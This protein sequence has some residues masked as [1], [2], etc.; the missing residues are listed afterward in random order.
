MKI[1]VSRVKKW[2]L[3]LV[4]TVM[5]TAAL[6]VSAS[7]AEDMIATAKANKVTSGKLV[8]NSKGIRF[9]Y[10][11]GKYAKNTWLY[12][13]SKVYSFK[14]NGYANKGF[15]TYNG[16][17]YYADSKGRVY[18]K[19]WVTKS[20]K[21]YYLRATGE[22]AANVTLKLNGKIYKFDSKGLVVKDSGA[23]KAT[24][25]FVGDSRTVGM[26]SA[27]GGTANLYIGKV[28]MGYNWLSKTADAKIRSY[29][30]ENPKLKVIFAFGVN[31]L[32]NIN[33]YISYYKKLIKAYPDTSFYFMSVNPISSW[34]QTSSL[35]NAKIKSFNKK[36][37]AAFPD[38][39]INTYSY[40]TKNGFSSSDGVHYKAA[41]YKKI[42]NYVIKQIK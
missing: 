30:K 15:F 41:T 36:L 39:Y 7:A 3:L 18:Y 14:S 26:K 24:Y 28:S 38:T 21:R 6:C 19:K 42:Y 35:S 16:K 4:M 5:M 9:K 32:G 34:R 12:Y 17:K 25:L 29:L 23:S 37:K 27:V 22:R 11:D 1:S 2:F 20:G 33:N 31:D 40:L 10:N 13:K 8:S